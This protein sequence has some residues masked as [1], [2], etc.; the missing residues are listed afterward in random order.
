MVILRKIIYFSLLISNF[1][2]MPIYAQTTAEVIGIDLPGLAQSIQINQ[3]DPHVIYVTVGKFG[4]YK[5]TDGGNTFNPQNSGLALLE[6]GVKSAYL[7]MSQV[8]PNC[9]YVNFYKTAGNKTFYTNDG[10]D[11]WFKPTSMDEVGVM[12]TKATHFHSAPITTSPVVE[13]VAITAS[14]G[15][16]LEKTTDGGD[17]WTYSGSGFSWGRAAHSCSFSWDVNDPGRF[18]LFLIDFGAYITEDGGDTFRNLNV[19]HN[20]GLTTPVGALDPTFGSKV[21]ITAVGDLGNQVIAVS[22]DEGQNWTLVGHTADNYTFMAFHPQDAN[23]IY[24]NNYKSSDKGVTWSKVSKRVDALFQEDGDVVYST[25]IINN[26][27]TIYKS[28]DGGIT[29]VEPYDRVRT[30]AGSIYETVVCSGDG[31]KIYVA[32]SDGIYIWDVIHWNHITEI[33]GL[34]RDKFGSLITHGIATDPDNQNVIYAGKLNWQGHANGIFRSADYGET[35]ENISYNLGTE[36]NVYSISINP[37]NSDV[38][39]GSSHGSFK[40]NRGT[41]KFSTAID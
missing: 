10:G 37:H 20:N 13:N 4:V 21:V 5:S 26:E 28:V 9:L 39:I 17:V 24:A 3:D 18:A 41:T 15:G 1:C 22:Q 6:E 23:I 33:N 30:D 34:K 8:N 40:L 25:E 11:Y 31:D 14:V 38:F 29:W 27:L 16:H 2:V 19:P 35:W 12:G 32:T 7:K 36:F